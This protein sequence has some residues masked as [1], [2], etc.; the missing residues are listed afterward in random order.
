M[1]PEFTEQQSLGGRHRSEQLSLEAA[2]RPATIPGFKVEKLL[3][4]GAFGQ[5]WLG[6]DLN[7]SRQ[8]A[9]KF[10]MHSSSVNWTLLRQ[11]VKHLVS[12]ST[13]RYV[14]QVLMVG[15]DSDPP[16][17]VMEY[18]ENGSIGDLI[19]E[20]GQLSVNET[21]A[22]LREVAD[23]LAYAH[24]KGVLHCD[25]KPANILLDH[26]SRPRLADFG[27]SR[28]TNDQT[29]S[30]GTLFFM[31]PEQADLQATPDVSWDIYALGAIA[32]SMLVGAPPYRSP[33]VIE[34]IDTAGTL[35][36]RL[37]RY[38]SAILAAPRPRLHYRRRGI[39][40]SLCQIIDRCLAP[41]PKQRFRNVQEIIGAIDVRNHA[42]VRRP[43]YLMGVLGPVFLLL[44]ML[45]F[46][47]RSI[48][49]AMQESL[50]RVQQL[51]LRGNVQ[52]AKYAKSTMESEIR[53]L[54]KLVELEASR[55]ELAELLSDAVL[56]TEPLLAQ[57]DDAPIDV[58]GLRKLQQAA[59]IAAL[60]DYL[61]LRLKAAISNE[62]NGSG[63]AIFNSLFVNERRGTNMGITFAN[64]EEETDSPIGKNFA[65]RSY[66]NGQREDGDRNAPS[67]NY[68]PTR[69]PHLS[70]SFRSTSTGKWK[71]G[72]SAPIWPNA[73]TQSDP[74]GQSPPVPR[75]PVGVLVLT[76]NLGDFVLLGDVAA[77]VTQF[78]TLVD[79]RSGNQRGTLLQHPL[80][81]SMDKVTMR[82]STMPQMDGRQLERLLRS[83]GIVDY[84][85]P[86]AEFP[87]GQDYAGTWIA[88]MS[89]VQIPHPV[90]E[91]TATSN[92][93]PVNSVLPSK[94]SDLWV[95]VQEKG[96]TVEAPVTELGKR[97]QNE[98][99]KALGALLLLI[100]VV[101]LSIFQFGQSLIKSVLRL[102][103]SERVVGSIPHSALEPTV[104]SDR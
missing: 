36:E 50:E 92:S 41:D 15:W 73:N 98:S 51:S 58:E 76:V 91:S 21:V 90:A 1:E 95:L 53:S 23:G 100:L 32:Y 11:E 16:Y 5:V 20:R 39:D 22:I 6:R 85:D 88:A 67:S 46:S 17:Y 37:K 31:A 3:G 77:G 80:I 33:E 52:T 96:E 35:P 12:M 72:I 8:V 10:C 65:Y 93:T 25:L 18:L 84:L 24:G 57:M 101:W 34:E 82:K 27:Q 56:Q 97:L 63:V 14:V 55:S 94:N 13:G 83:D 99:Y 2:A 74:P 62:G 103:G 40:K 60:Q 75:E 87:G 7:T 54:F 59:A 78:T 66:F 45:L 104:Q 9:I 68:R 29:P 44:L 19:R 81:A 30:L 42:R 79:G 70:A 48:S 26:S 61:D 69:S 86:A 43:L 71:L 47:N 4:Q 64:P 89:Q 49:I 102:L 38:Q 28:M